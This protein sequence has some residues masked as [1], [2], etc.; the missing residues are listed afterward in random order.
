MVEMIHEMGLFDDV[1]EGVEEAHA[2]AQL[3]GEQQSC[4]QGG[5]VE[6]SG[7]NSDYHCKFLTCPQCNVATY[8]CES[9]MKFH[10]EEHALECRCLRD[11]AEPEGED[12]E[13]RD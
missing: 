1:D 5:N 9:H 11:S 6:Q 8:C 4:W 10:A 12:A 2:P 13:A 7:E 3:M